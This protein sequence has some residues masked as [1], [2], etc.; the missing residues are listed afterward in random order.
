MLNDI[1]HKEHV[2]RAL[3]HARI[4]IDCGFTLSVQ[5]R[6]YRTLQIVRAGNVSW[7]AEI[8]L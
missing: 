8:Q 3:S 4:I 5:E 1:L 6:P 2:H 7:Y